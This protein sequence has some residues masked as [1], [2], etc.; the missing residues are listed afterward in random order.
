MGPH[1]EQTRANGSIFGRIASG[2][3]ANVLGKGWTLAVQLAAIPVLTTAWG[4]HGYGVWLMVSAVPVYISLSDFGFGSAAAVLMTKRYAIGDRDGA[5]AAFQSGWAL[6]TLATGAISL[7]ACALWA[8]RA[9]IAATLGAPAPADDVSHALILLTLYAA[10]L[11]Q[12]NYVSTVFRATG[13][14]G[15]GVVL[16]DVIIPIEG[17]V[18]IGVALTGGGIVEAAAA[19]FITQ[20]IGLVV[21]YIV[22]RRMAPWARFGLARASARLLRELTAPALGTLSIVASHAIALQ[23]S[24]LAVGFALSPTAAA[25]FGTVRSLTRIPLQFTGA[26]SRAAIPEISA[27]HARHDSATSATLAAMGL[28]LAVAVAAPSALFLTGF[29]PWLLR[30][31]SDS[32][33]NA[34]FVVFGT[35]ALAMALQTLWTVLSQ[36]LLAIGRQHVVA[37]Y[38]LPIAGLIAVAPLTMRGAFALESASLFI[39]AAEALMLVIVWRGFHAETALGAAQLRAAGAGAYARARALILKR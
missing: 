1:E 39:M 5:L 36:Y 37:H 34:S 9:P 17:L 8:W 29:G 31:M 3:A 15:L 11:L 12:Y 14:Y 23:G 35:L 28:A 10:L 24:L 22:M 16:Q 21:F 4:T 25:V 7:A 13:R 33:L 19:T 20:G 30:L 26:L 27:A 32:A 6:L 2:V 38:Y 18:L